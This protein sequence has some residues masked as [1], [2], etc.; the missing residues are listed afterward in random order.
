MEIDRI[1]VGSFTINYSPESPEPSN[2][3]YMV[4]Q[5]IWSRA[6]P[7]RTSLLEIINS[8]SSWRCHIRWI[9]RRA[10]CTTES[11]H[12]VAILKQRVRTPVVGDLQVV[13]APPALSVPWFHCQG[14]EFKY[15]HT[16]SGLWGVVGKGTRTHRYRCPS[17]R[18]SLSC[19]SGYLSLSSWIA[20]LTGDGCWDGYSDCISIYDYEYLSKKGHICYVLFV[21]RGRGTF[22]IDAV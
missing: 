1:G 22:T 13:L 4:N 12:L 14:Q 15:L 3:T 5:E 11:P 9:P 20:V 7:H 18:K 8:S 17:S 2:H 21:D 16:H 19:L 10:P 6:F